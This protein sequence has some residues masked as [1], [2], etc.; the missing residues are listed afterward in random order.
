MYKK[1][2]PLF[3]LCLGIFIALRFAAAQRH[4]PEVY[5]KR[6][7]VVPE[8]VSVQNTLLLHPWIAT[9][10]KINQLNAEI[11]RDLER[12]DVVCT[13]AG[14]EPGL[15]ITTL[16]R[17]QKQIPFKLPDTF[18]SLICLPDTSPFHVY[19]RLYLGDTEMGM[20]FY[21][22]VRV[23]ELEEASAH[24]LIAWHLDLLE[25]GR[26]ELYRSENRAVYLSSGRRKRDDAHGFEMGQRG[27]FVDFLEKEG[28]LFVLYAEG[29]LSTFREYQS[30]FNQL[31]QETYD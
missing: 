12:L 11:V 10:P 29:P 9:Q 20:P 6:K 16:N 31:T 28:R 26:E 3:V 30:L 21:L 1:S 8:A 19:K 13:K 14:M 15:L 18:Y 4:S 24:E 22:D 27:L 23:F 25:G 5:E 7:P 17:L 2:W